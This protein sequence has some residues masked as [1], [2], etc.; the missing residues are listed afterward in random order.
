[1]QLDDV[2]D[3]VATHD[4]RDA[5][6]DI[7]L[8][9]LTVQQDRDRKD[10]VLVV[11]DGADDLRRRRADAE[12]GAALAAQDGPAALAARI[13]EGIEVELSE[14]VRI[15]L[16]PLAE[17]LAGN[18]DGRPRDHLALAVLAERV[19]G[20]GFLIDAGL[21]RDRAA[22]SCGVERGARGKDTLRRPVQRVLNIMRDNVRRV[23]DIDD[24]TVKAGFFDGRGNFLQDLDGLPQRIH[25][26]LVAARQRACRD[27]HDLR[28]GGIAVIT[29]GDFGADRQI[30]GRVGQIERL[31]DS[32]CAV[33]IDVDDLVCEALRDQ[34]IADVGAD[35]A[36]AHDNNFTIGN[37]HVRLSLMRVLPDDL[38]ANELHNANDNDQDQHRDVGDVDHVAVVAVADGEIAQTACAD[39][40]RHCGE[41][42][43]ADGR[44]GR[45]ACDRRDAFLEVDAEDDLKRRRAHGERRLDQTA[46]QLR[47]R[48][49]DLP[50]EERHRAEH[51]RNDRAAHIQRR[52]HDDAGERHDP[53]QQDD[54]R[55]GAEQA[56]QLVDDL[57]DDFVFQNAARLCDR[58]Q[59]AERQTEHE[60]D[61]TRPDHHEQCVTDRRIEVR[62]LCHDVR[63][64]VI[65]KL[66]HP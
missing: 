39:N 59:H 34:R 14:R 61:R 4:R 8:T 54:E 49:L 13:G 45:A 11:E 19:C 36:C 57:V 24:N 12:L 3:A 29:G 25:A 41:V 1:M 40:A 66:L 7:V 15:L 28:I 55:D 22:Q 46:V 31:C 9:V 62:Q 53:R 48:A 32:L 52:A 50:G 10:A 30:V 27:D 42:E 2:R 26:G 44:D 6:I 5:R 65:Q 64:D 17:R 16:A 18:G 43:Q 58:E 35:V 33:G 47:E 63:N 51:Q 21:M 37:T 60:R 23:G 38:A 20:D 56:D